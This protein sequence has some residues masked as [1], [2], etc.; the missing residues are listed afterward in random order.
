MNILLVD[1]RVSQYETIIESIDTA[2]AIGITFDYYV[3][4]FESLKD[5]IGAAMASISLAENMNVSTTSPPVVS[6]GLIQHNYELPMFCAL[7]V[8]TPSAVLNV[9]SC[10]NNLST[11]VQVREFIAWLKSAL[12]AVYFDMMACA[13]YSNPDWKY[14][15]DTLSS[16]T[17]VEIRAS[18][19][20]TGSA[21]LGGNWFL[22][23]HTGVNLK[24]VYFTDKIEKYLWTLVNSGLPS[25]LYNKYSTKSFVKGQLISVGEIYYSEPYMDA[26]SEFIAVSCTRTGIAALKTDGSVVC[27]GQATF[28][29]PSSVTMANSNVVSICVSQNAFAAL[30]SDGSVVCWGDSND[31]DGTTPSISGTVVSIYST[32]K[33]FA[34]LKSDGSVVCW[35]N[36][37]YGGTAPSSVTMANSNVVTIYS[38]SFAFVALKSNG[39]IT[40]WGDSRYGGA[41]NTSYKYSSNINTNVVTVYS[42]LAAFAALKSDG[43]VFT[44]G[45]S[46]N[47]NYGGALGD[48]RNGVSVATNVIT[49]CSSKSAFAALKSNGSVV[50]WGGYNG[51]EFSEP[52][53]V[54]SNVISIYSTYGDG[55]FRTKIRWS[56]VCWGN[57]DYGGTTPSTSISGTIVG[58]YGMSYAFVALKSNMSL[59]YWAYPTITGVNIIG[60]GSENIINVVSLGDSISFGILTKNGNVTKMTFNNLIPLSSYFQNTVALYGGQARFGSLIAIT[61]TATTYSLNY[62]Y[63]TDLDRFNILRKKENR[64]RVDLTIDN[65]NVH[66]LSTVSDIQTFNPNMPTNKPLKI[67][68]PDYSASSTLSRISTVTIPAANSSYGYVIACDEGEP[69]T[70]GAN[71]ITYVNFGGFVYKVEVNNTFTKIST[72]Q[73]IL[74]TEYELYGGDG[75]NSSGIALLAAAAADD[76]LVTLSDVTISKKYKHTFNPRVL[77]STSYVVPMFDVQLIGFPVLNNLTSWTIDIVF[78]VKSDFTAAGVGWRA[79]LGSMYYDA[80]RTRGWGIWVS[81]AN[82][83][84]YS[85]STNYFTT[86][87]QV[88]L[89][90]PYNLNIV[91]DE[92]T[93]TFTLTNISANTSL[94]PFTNSNVTDF[95]GTGPVS[96]GG[97]PLYHGE[98]FPGTISSVIVK[99]KKF[100]VTAVPTGVRITYYSNPNY[101]NPSPPSSVASISPTGL[102]T[103]NNTNNVGTVT[104]TARQAQ[105]GSLYSW[106]VILD[107]SEKVTPVLTN[108]TI[109]KV[110]DNSVTM[111]PDI[112]NYNTGF[113]KLSDYPTKWTM[114]IGFKVSRIINNESTNQFLGLV[115]SCFN[116]SENDY[117]WGVWVSQ[118]NKIFFTDY[119]NTYYLD[120]LIVNMVDDY[121]LNLTKVGS[122]IFYTLTNKSQNTS[123]SQTGPTNAIGIGPVSIGGWRIGGGAFAGSLKQKFEGI[124]YYVLVKEAN[125]SIGDRKVFYVTPPTSNSDGTMHYAYQSGATSNSAV[126]SIT[127][128]GL[129]TIPAIQT[130]GKILFTASQDETSIYNSATSTVTLTVFIKVTPI[131]TNFSIPSKTIVDENFLVTAPTSSI[132]GGTFAY[133]SSNQSVA[134]ITSGNMIHIVGAGSTTITATQAET[135]NYNTAS[136]SATF[137][138]ATLSAGSDL[139]GK[140]LSGASLV[141]LTLTNVIFSNSNLSN[142]NLSNSY[143]SNS[144]FSNSNL[145]G[146]NFSGAIIN[147]T[148]FTNASI[149]GATGLPEFSTKQKLQLLYNANNAGAN[150]P[151]LQFSAPL[152]VSDLNAALSVPIPEL[153]S[154]KTEFLI[155]APVYVDGVKTVTIAESSISSVNNTSFYIPLN[156][157]E[158]VKI[159]GES[160][161]LNASNQLLDD[162]GVVLK[163]MVVNGCPFK[164]Y[165]GSII[166]LNNIISRINNMILLSIMKKHLDLKNKSNYTMF[167]D[168]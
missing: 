33:A 138:V 55:F 89:N 19:D 73:N 139:L 26:S 45:G 133:T 8:Q 111:I 71:G 86:G 105:N 100:Q 123:I 18:T 48:I 124:I 77:P 7:S 117:I 158:I 126:A 102:I 35:G 151:Q 4:T 145:N 29:T 134:I 41:F 44:W 28:I 160:F 36:S 87:L 164:I 58:I 13:L 40:M 53:N 56:V 113:P 109:S 106:N 163:L 37:N 156:K 122:T 3:D 94:T 50:C 57:G 137:S 166:L 63:Y 147:G 49:L 88:N 128:W 91:K 24:N 10:D 38:N 72:S 142:S 81:A 96:I 6:V 161:T 135:D 119:T 74:G 39:T 116:T 79:L 12:G 120:D 42:T 59:Y 155:A 64:R 103:I 149:V 150:I 11:W 21:A 92:T 90:V 154:V 136:I 27:I 34:A 157:G 167:L 125:F 121:N 69:V 75:V 146:A 141:G 25:H 47:A 46:Y 61:S 98:D 101:S 1:F 67:I 127:D 66:T 80:A 114:D 130:L 131:L 152:S 62:S 162:K 148:D 132:V 65:N 95:I 97:W 129:I 83:I 22:E 112:P 68:I 108:V 153:E 115:G 144:N 168:Q 14:V 85:Q 17:G 93:V 78:T 15:I 2:L 165:S 52:S 43:T 30:K 20:A 143:L 99:E 60:S 54:S 110:Y 51:N 16:Q 5:K 118:S 31:G 76:T 23:S 9:E 159:N 82:E 104:F 84:F 107:V 32:D 140:N 70:I